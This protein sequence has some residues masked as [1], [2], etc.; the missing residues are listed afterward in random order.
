MYTLEAKLICING[1]LFSGIKIYRSLNFLLSVKHFIYYLLALSFII[2]IA[3]SLT[4]LE[5]AVLSSNR[6]G[7]WYGACDVN[8]VSEDRSF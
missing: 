6:V 3:S 4:T 8:A 5:N 7:K 1:I 2:K